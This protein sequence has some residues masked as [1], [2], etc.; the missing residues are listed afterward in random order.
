MYS[1]NKSANP[2]LNAISNGATTLQNGIYAFNDFLMGLGFGVEGGKGHNLTNKVLNYTQKNVLKDA[3]LAFTIPITA[4]G[5][6]TVMQG[7][8]L[9][10]P[11]LPHA[12]GCISLKE[13]IAR[14][15][16]GNNA[17]AVIP[18]KGNRANEVL[19]DAFGT[20]IAKV[21]GGA[22]IEY[23]INLGEKGVF[24]GTNQEFRKFVEKVIDESTRITKNTGSY[25]SG[26]KR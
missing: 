19:S 1:N 3:A 13:H 21:D 4:G 5:S 9:L 14:I 15:S 23:N 25:T 22:K 10:E 8:K 26:L 6:A 12:D 20:A 11:V 18:L 16:E 2:V 7:S 17:E 24:L